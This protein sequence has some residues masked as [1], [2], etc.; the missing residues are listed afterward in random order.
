VNTITIDAA[1]LNVP[2]VRSAGDI[3]NIFLRFGV[4][5]VLRTRQLAQGNCFRYASNSYW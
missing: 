5:R 2:P 4:T 1:L 3:T